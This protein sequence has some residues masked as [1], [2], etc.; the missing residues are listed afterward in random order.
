MENIMYKMKT[1]SSGGGSAHRG[2]AK[3]VVST[4]N[5]KVKV[6]FKDEP[7]LPIILDRSDC[8]E[9]VQ[10][11]KW[12]VTLSSAEDI[13]FNLYPDKG[14]FEVRVKEFISGEDGIPE[15]RLK[16]VSFMKDGKE[17]SYDYEYFMVIGEIVNSPSAN[18][19][20]IPLMFRYH[21]DSIKEDGVDV[22]C[23]SK[24]RSKYTNDLIDFFVATGVLDFGAIKYSDNILPEVEKRVLQNNRTFAVTLRDGWMVSGSIMAIESPNETEVPWEEDEP[25]EKEDIVEFDE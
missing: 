1:K 4:D 3:V 5:T 7:S 24:P 23:Y 13:M 9:N 11:G 18:G 16:H 10:N 25:K 15:P 19:M 21:F 2:L 6:I 20:E 22:T 8:P 14:T 17:N 12:F